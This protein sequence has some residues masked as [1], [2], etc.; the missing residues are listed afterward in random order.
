MNKQFHYFSTIV[1][2]QGYIHKIFIINE[3]LHYFMPIHFKKILPN[4]KW[5]ELVQ[6][7]VH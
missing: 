2:Q 1:G 4:E 7:W 6:N 3:Q 5:I